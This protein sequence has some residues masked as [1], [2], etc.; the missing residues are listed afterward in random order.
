[1]EIIADENMS[2]ATV[3]LLR[4]AG[5]NVLAV[6]ETA[7]GI[8]DEEVLALARRTAR[9]LVTSDKG[10]GSLIYE[11]NLSPPPGLILF[12]IFDVRAE[13]IPYFILGSIVAL[14]EWEGVFQVIN[15]HGSRSRPLPRR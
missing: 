3:G 13:V 14:Q 9:V 1:M 8:A 15:Q 11:R 2:D 12:R 4:S 6:S 10:F 7:P 5:Y